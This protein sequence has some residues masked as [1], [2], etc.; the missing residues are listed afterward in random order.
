LT[1][2]GTGSANWIGKITV[3]GSD[4]TG[5]VRVRLPQSRLDDLLEELQARLDAAAAL[6]DA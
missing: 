5:E 2:D 1:L 4:G 3:G 6:V